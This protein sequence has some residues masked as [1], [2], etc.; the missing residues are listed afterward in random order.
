VIPLAFAAVLLALTAAGCRGNDDAAAAP[1]PTS[2][3]ANKSVVPEDTAKLEAARKEAQAALDELAKQYP[4]AKDIENYTKSRDQGSNGYEAMLAAGGKICSTLDALASRPDAP[5]WTKISLFDDWD[6][7]LK[8]DDLSDSDRS[9]VQACVTSAADLIDPLRELLKFPT[10]EGPVVEA[11][12]TAKVHDRLRRSQAPLT[13]LKN[14]AFIYCLLGKSEEALS[15]VKLCVQVACRYNDSGTLS[16]LLLPDLARRIA[17]SAVSGVASRLGPEALAP[18]RKI[19]T[20]YNPW[21]GARECWLGECAFVATVLAKYLR[22]GREGVEGLVG[23]DAIADYE[24][25]EFLAEGAATLRLLMKLYGSNSETARLLDRRV[26]E[27]VMAEA[28][29]HAAALPKR[30]H[31]NLKFMVLRPALTEAATD[32]RRVTLALVLIR[33]ECTSEQ[34]FEAAAERQLEQEPDYELEW[35]GDLLSVL[36]VDGHPGNNAVQHGPMGALFRFKDVPL[37]SARD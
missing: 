29:A 37:G 20:E 24:P 18:L 33:L 23:S 32:A 31:D 17:E 10:I 11:D 26:A 3:G 27:K 21:I 12:A 19:V 36:T 7:P 13:F 9:F 35:D 30:C 15:S 16:S 22:S 8:A 25:H 14:S 2:N 4:R 1:V 6:V 5:E 34:D 28:A